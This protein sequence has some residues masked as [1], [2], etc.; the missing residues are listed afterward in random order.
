MI[1]KMKILAVAAAAMTTVLGAGATAVVLS[2]DIEQTV[3]AL[4]DGAAVDESN[5][6]SAS[7]LRT[8]WGYGYRTYGWRGYY[9]YRGYYG[10]RAPAQRTYAWRGYYGPRWAGYWGGW[11]ARTYVIRW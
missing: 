3:A 4:D 10:W 2:D 1:S 8:R 9:G 5:T 11:R 6:E 7:W